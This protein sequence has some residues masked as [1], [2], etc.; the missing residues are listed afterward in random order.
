MIIT[1]F[2]HYLLLPPGGGYPYGVEAGPTTHGQI[3]LHGAW[4]TYDEAAA[5]ADWMRGE[6]ADY[7]YIKI[8]R[9]EMPEVS[10]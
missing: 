6:Y 4:K 7:E 2:C 9:I 1:G 5:H 3:E 10:E 8:V